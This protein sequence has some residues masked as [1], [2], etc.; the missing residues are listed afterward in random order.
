MS[1]IASP[2]E[3]D[4]SAPELNAS[5]LASAG[6]GKTYL[7]VTR[8]LRLLLTG[9]A[10]DGI[11]AITF[12]RKAAAEMQARLNDRLLA[13]AQTPAEQLG[14]ELERLGIKPLAEVRARA[15]RLYEGLLLAPASVRT[16]TFHAFCQDILRRF[17]LEAEVPPGFELLDRTGEYTQAAWDA[18]F[19]EATA[20]PDGALARD[21]E[22]L[23]EHC[24]GL[25]GTESALQAFLEHRSDWWALTAPASD[26]AE[27]AAQY[28]AQELGVDAHS[29]PAE[30]FLESG[31]FAELSEFAQWL[32]RH[33][34]NR[35]SEHADLIRT[36]LEA[37]APAAERLDRLASAFFTSSGLRSRPESKVQ[38]KAMGIEGQA[39]FLMLH[40]RLAEAIMQT[41]DRGRAQ[42][43]FLVSTA[44][45]RAGQRL[46]EHFQRIKAEQRLLD[47]ADLEWRAYRLLNHADNHLWVQYKLD[48]RIDH[49]LIDEFQDTNPIQWR[50]LLPLLEELAAG[51]GD[52]VRSVFLV[53]DAKQSIYGF[54]R[55]DPGLLGSAT[56]WLKERLDARTHPLRTSWRSAPAVIRCVNQVFTH[57]PLIPDFEPHE[58]HQTAL[59]GRVELLP[60]ANASTAP[61]TPA[62]DGL[63]NPLLQSRIIPCD[64]RH[65]REGQAIAARIRQLL[66]EGVL[67]GTDRDTRPLRPRDVMI[68]LRSRTHA[69]DYERALREADLPYLGA[70]RGTL[71]HNPEIHDMEALLAVLVAPFNNLALATVL[72]SPLFACDDADLIRLGRATHWHA[73]LAEIAP[74]LPPQAPLHRAA[75]LLSRWRTRI[76][77]IPVHDLLDQIYAEGDVLRRYHSAFPEPLRARAR[78]NLIRFLELA[79]EIDSGR[80]PSLMH[81]LARLRELR[82]HAQEAPDEAPAEGDEDR[83]RILTIHAA[84]GLEAPMVFLVDCARS[85]AANRAYRAL[86]DWPSGAS[87]PRSLLLARRKDELDPRSRELCARQEAAERREDANLLYVALTRARQWLFISASAP[88]RGKDLGWYGAVA[89]AYQHDPSAIAEP[90][91]LE[92]SN[93]LPDTFAQ[94]EAQSVAPPAVDPRLGMPL[95]FCRADTREIAPSYAAQPETLDEEA[96]EDGRARGLLLHALLD[97]LTRSPPIDRS[98]LLPRLAAQAGSARSAAQLEECWQEARALVDDPTLAVLYKAE[99]FDRAYNE[100]PIQYRDGPRTVYGV[101]DRLVIGDDAVTV[102]DYKTHRGATADNIEAVAAGYEEQMRLYAE[103]VRRLWP[104]RAVRCL[105]LFTHPR[106]AFELPV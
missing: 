77:K 58:T 20:D 4:P 25:G 82:A 61:E 105:L 14:V 80:Y 84:K 63:R 91:L 87:A 45:Y 49:L 95:P 30:D 103:G 66:D 73:R 2:A 89:E 85:P 42:A 83:I 26:P 15:E 16:T 10:P 100:V 90:I 18:L 92:E 79:L 94:T 31:I 48:Q 86:V 36:Q 97:G 47:F 50:L 7:L 44:W 102:V 41:L 98:V 8:I 75:R 59:Y 81:F 12:T 70:D 60:L 71:L 67:V 46:L 21:L 53:G 6:T 104:G 43:T 19:A 51:A 93:R 72:R 76:G 38:A 57:A 39:R 33:P 69:V 28:L 35:N 65:Y 5:V 62:L 40:H 37:D 54:R 24:G 101:I 106:L 32:D 17:P 74:T 27:A 22:S 29:R 55:A 1:S 3:E 78:A 34:T 56:G 11:L 9:A 99:S 23:F 68:L 64:D 96:D 13:L 52:R 88:N